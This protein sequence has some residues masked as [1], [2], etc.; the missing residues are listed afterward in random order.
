MTATMPTQTTARAL[1]MWRGNL[2]LDRAA[3]A[4]AGCTEAVGRHGGHRP[5]DMDDRAGRGLGPRS[6][7]PA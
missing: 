4:V 7:H 6:A 2:K 5:D 1:R 3:L